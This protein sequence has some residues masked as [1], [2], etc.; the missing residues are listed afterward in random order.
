[1]DEPGLSELTP[2]YIG[3][4]WQVDEDGNWLLPERT[5]GWEIAGW[6]Y[7]YLAAE[8][9]GPWNFT[10]EQL[11]FILWWYAV[12]E[13]GRFVYRTG[14]LQRMKGWGKDPLLAVLCL[15]ELCG[16]SRV[17][18]DSFNLPVWDE[19]GQPTGEAHP[20]AWI[21]ITAV[22]QSQTTNTMALI[23]SL[24]T[25]H[26]KAT[27]DIE[28]GAVLIRAMGAKCRLEAVT[29]SYRALEGKRTTFTLLNEALA[30]DTP[31][32]TPGGFKSMGDLVDGDVI[33]GSDGKPTI[34]TKAHGVQV[35]RDCFR[36]HFDDGSSLVASDGHW[37]K[38][39][40]AKN[41][42]CTVREMTTREM[43]QAGREF[44]LPESFTA[45]ECEPADLPV[46]PY[47]L[48]LWLGDGASQSSV[49]ATD[50]QDA[51]ELLGYLQSIEPNARMVDD[52]HIS[53][54]QCSTRK[55][56][57]VQEKLRVLGVLGSK[58][59]PAPYMRASREQRLELLRGLMDSDG[60]VRRGGHA[61]FANTD[62][63]L[64]EQVRELLISLGYHVREAKFQ[65]RA[66]DRAH[67]KPLG[68]I[69]FKAVES[70]N[71]F[72]LKRKAA[73]VTGESSPTRDRLR[74][75][76]RIEQ[77]GSVPV[78]CISVAAEDRLFLAGRG[79]HATRNTH[80]WVAGN[81]GHKMFDTIDG[82]AT[83]KQSRYL[84]ITNAY[85]PGEDSVAERMREAY[86]KI[87]DG[88][89]VDVRFLYD[90]IEAHPKTPLTPEALRHVIPLIR[91]DA[92]WLDVEDIITSIQTT[93]IAPSRS[94]RMWLNQ[95]VADE[96]ALYA[97]H[98]WDELADPDLDGLVPGEPI[99]LG[100]DGGKTDDDTALVAIRVS[101]RAAFKL[102]H[103]YKPDEWPS[104]PDAPKWE[105]DKARVNDAVLNV[106]A[107]YKV[108][109]FFADVA[110]W[111]SYIDAWAATSTARAFKVKANG[112]H[113]IAF[114]MRGQI[115]RGTRAHESLMSAILEG[116]IK[117]DGDRALRR[118]VLNAR[119]RENAYGVSF[120][121]ESRESPRKVD[122][123]AAL[124][125][126][127]AA[128]TDLTIKAKPEKERSGRGYFT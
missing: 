92:H 15:V 100:F 89:A 108:V 32:P 118:H 36:V 107:T 73:V 58:H 16:P 35:G 68:Q 47:F 71:P 19:H 23:P 121:K 4:T 127:F 96:D 82:N 56:G 26:F 30:L 75:I 10:D 93:T 54:T 48:G 6:T 39:R 72:R 61:R 18:R 24:M 41:R 70:V 27:Y 17:R 77:V 90:S 59:I 105:V 103:W 78:R 94:R 114:D 13:S 74:R 28:E 125:L 124:M 117:H 88:F 2:D 40:V 62:P 11:R 1:M 29:S 91:G 120:G 110:L 111:E 7:E 126:A 101:D 119:R 83:K 57:S 33:Y 53:M 21:Q 14:V 51:E 8:D 46:D 79:M 55:P 49:I 52:N 99:T 102:G 38:V 69:S 3:P 5:L 65:T 63:G 81:H 104:G 98:E 116:R 31:I 45:L 95:V 115:Q 128:Y 22:N 84:A 20:A 37:W 50:T 34:V 113:A 12:D 123:Y 87:R 66:G 76:V 64:L 86:E 97:P 25:D 112:N 85:L 67:W 42:A 122:L 43:F 109:A 60:S 9:G 80:H 106:L 44:Y